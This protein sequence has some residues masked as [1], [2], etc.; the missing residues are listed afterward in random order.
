MMAWNDRDRGA[1]IEQISA[2]GIKEGAEKQSIWIEYRGNMM[3]PCIGQPFDEGVLETGNRSSKSIINRRRRRRRRRALADSDADQKLT[4]DLY[5]SN[6]GVDILALF[7]FLFFSFLFFSCK[8]G[9]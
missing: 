9:C 2:S 1:E 4:P 3:E 8:Q 7:S 6:R 5:R